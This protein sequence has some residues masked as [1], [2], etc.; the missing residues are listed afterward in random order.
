MR[1]PLLE[2]RLEE[3]SLPANY[4]IFIAMLLAINSQLRSI[5]IFRADGLGAYQI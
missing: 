3:E 2:E 5:C 1:A 4:S